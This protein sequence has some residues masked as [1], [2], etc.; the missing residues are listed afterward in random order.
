MTE[1]ARRQAGKTDYGEPKFIGLTH[2]QN[3]I[4]DL[5]S[6]GNYTRD[7]ASML[8]VWLDSLIMLLFVMAVFRLRWYE[9]LV[10]RDR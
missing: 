9:E 6:N 1:I 2:C 5:G 8:I 4:I 10:E 3:N 7:E